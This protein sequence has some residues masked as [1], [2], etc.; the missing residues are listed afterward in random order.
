MNSQKGLRI[1]S[2]FTRKGK[3]E[4]TESELILPALMYLQKVKKPQ[5]T[6]SLISYLQELL[7]PIGHDAEIISGRQDTYFS[8]KVRNLKSHNSLVNMKLA[9]Y[10]NGNWSITEDGRKFL[11]ANLAAINGLVEQGFKPKQISRTDEYDYTNIVIEEGAL[12]VRE[13]KNR[14]RSDK[15]RT[16]AIAQFKKDH[17]G[18]IFCTICSFS[19]QETYGVSYIEAHHTDPIHEKDMRGETVLLKKALPKIALVCSNCHR[20]V[21]RKK[22]KMLT[23]QQLKDLVKKHKCAK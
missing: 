19:F 5:S 2:A 1:L 17:E 18:K 12:V 14:K 9:K 15:L 3:S 11:D 21:H 6:S 7:C 23:I 10:K 20:M 4:Y 13:I 16:V 8:Q 22:G